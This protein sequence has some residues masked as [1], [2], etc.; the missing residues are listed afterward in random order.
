MTTDFFIGI[1]KL[2]PAVAFFRDDA[3][4]DD[5]ARTNLQQ[6]FD[7]FSPTT[8]VKVIECEGRENL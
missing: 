2:K 1:A 3:F 6:A 7:Q 8:S 5:S 4:A